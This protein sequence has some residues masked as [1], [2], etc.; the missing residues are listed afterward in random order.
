M[1]HRSTEQLDKQ[2]F[3][4]YKASKERYGKDLRAIFSWAQKNNTPVISLNLPFAYGHH[5]G[6][7]QHDIC[8]EYTQI[9]IHNVTQ[10]LSFREEDTEKY[11]HLLKRD[12]IDFVEASSKTFDIPLS[13][14]E[15]IFP[16]RK[17]FHDVCHLSPYGHARVAEDLSVL[18]AR[19][20]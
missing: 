11:A 7:H 13:E 15:G 19:F 14:L 10:D 17:A 18:L 3:S 4:A 6:H 2:L 16:F 8:S 5:Y 9:C 12:Y 1:M 20:Q